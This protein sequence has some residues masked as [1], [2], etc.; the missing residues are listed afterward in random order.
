MTG[1]L[2][3]LGSVNLQKKAQRISTIGPVGGAVGVV[4]GLVGGVVGGGGGAGGGGMVPGGGGSLTALSSLETT[5][6]ISVLPGCGDPQYC[7]V[8][9]YEYVFKKTILNSLLLWKFS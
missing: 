7:P 2:C 3:A 4:P 9:Q 8:T 5:P 6:K 1:F